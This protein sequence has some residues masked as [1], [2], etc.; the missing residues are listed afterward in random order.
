MRAEWRLPAGWRGSLRLRLLAGTLLWI[1]G[2]IAVAGWGL[3]SLF[4][5]HLARQFDAELETHLEQLDEVR[6]THVAQARA[7]IE[8]IERQRRL[9]EQ[10]KVRTADRTA[11]VRPADRVAVRVP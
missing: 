8:A 4:G 2:T 7:E 11:A 1:I 10:V 5:Q 3:S 6:S 9:L